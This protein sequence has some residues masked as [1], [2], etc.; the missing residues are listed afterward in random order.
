MSCL[1]MHW[2]LMSPEHHRHGISCVG[3]ITCIIVPCFRVYV[4]FLCQLKSKIWFKMYIYLLW[5]MIWS[6][7]LRVNNDSIYRTIALLYDH[8]GPIYDIA[9]LVKLSTCFL[10]ATSDQHHRCI[11]A[12]LCFSLSSNKPLSAKYLPFRV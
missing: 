9:L 6:S 2:F 3:Q 12:V 1:L 4:L 10:T 8:L 5:S 7:M 11:V